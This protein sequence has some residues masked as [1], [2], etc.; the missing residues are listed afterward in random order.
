MHVKVQ[1]YI[2]GLVD[3]TALNHIS[4]VQDIHPVSAW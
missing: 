2:M 3:K 4:S 1:K